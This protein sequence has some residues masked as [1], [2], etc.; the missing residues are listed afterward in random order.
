MA[1]EWYVCRVLTNREEK[2]KDNLV[3]RIKADGLE[4]RIPRVLV[5]VD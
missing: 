5:P 2:V 4:H 3:S 1:L